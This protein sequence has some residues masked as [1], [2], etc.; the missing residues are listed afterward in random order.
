MSW[1][2]RPHHCGDPSKMSRN[3]H[4]LQEPDVKEYLVKG[5]RFTKW[6]EVSPHH[7]IQSKN[8]EK[9]MRFWA[10][11]PVSSKNTTLLCDISDF[12][13][14][15]VTQVSFIYVYG[16]V[17]ILYLSQTVI[18]S[19]RMFFVMFYN[20]TLDRTP[21]KPHRSPWRW[22]PKDFTCSGSIRARSDAQKT[23]FCCTICCRTLFF[24][25]YRKI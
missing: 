6:K 1:S 2:A 22:I 5:D 11:C 20:K 21:R 7:H 10:L 9:Y 16:P 24:L 8:T 14:I 23:W 13:G 17:M 3:R 12:L 18:C 4:T 25:P 19:M 15:F